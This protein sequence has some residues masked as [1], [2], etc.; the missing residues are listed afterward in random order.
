MAV[1]SVLIA[2]QAS[3][4]GRTGTR[5]EDFIVPLTVAQDDGVASA[6]VV[7]GGSSLVEFPSVRLGDFRAADEPSEAM[8]RQVQETFR[9]VGRFLDRRPS[10]MFAAFRAAGL[11]VRLYVEVWIDQ[12]QMEVTLPPDLV[13]SCARHGIGIFVIS[14]DISAEEAIKMGAR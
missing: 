6:R 9:V 13:V 14:N 4:S 12:D 7:E 2:L 5:P 10:E 3:A 11:A 1:G 8:F